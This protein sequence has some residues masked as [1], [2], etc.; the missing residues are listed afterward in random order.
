M[1]THL[2]IVMPAYNE[3]D[4]IEAGVR[5]WYAEVVAKLPG[6][7]LIV[8][9]DC[10][11]DQT[12]A[13]LES[14]AKQMPALVPLRTPVNGGHGKALRYGFSH[15]R[16][17]FV[18]QTDSDR[19]HSPEDFWLLW[20]MRQ[21]ADFVFGVRESRA[22]GAL[23]M[24]IT[25]IMRFLN[26]LLWQCWIRDANCPFK[27]M[28]RASLERVLAQVPDDSFIPMVMVSILARYT[29]ARSIDVP[30]RHFARKGGEQSLKG[31]W[32][33]V[34]VGSRCFRQLLTLRGR[35]TR[36]RGSVSAV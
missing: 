8:V 9:N 13:V 7:E 27:L 23:R 26:L 15:A 29:G 22:D 12:G 32:N 35:A 3:G 33:W 34:K 25:G 16:G 2:S 21:E 17:E 24:V 19:Q 20:K 6:S 31:T 1:T 30:V 5:E 10:S 18:F 11:K 36:G 14:L 4:H 28:R